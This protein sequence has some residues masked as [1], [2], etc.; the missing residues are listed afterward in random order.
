MYKSV[1]LKYPF[2]CQ[3]FNQLE[4]SRKIFGKC[5]DTKF[6]E[7]SSTLKDVSCGRT[8]RQTHDEVNSRF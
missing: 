7:N 3:A 6:H 4:R 1:P 8:D 2:F 5:P